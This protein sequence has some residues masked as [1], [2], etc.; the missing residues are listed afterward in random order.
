MLSKLDEF[1]V[2]LAL[3]ASYMPLE[4]GRDVFH[5]TS[6]GGFSSILFGNPEKAELWASR[7]DC[8]NDASEGAIV[9]DILREV[10]D[11]M[12]CE[13]KITQ[14]LHSLFSTV[15]P[16]RT[17]LL[18]HY[19]G[20]TLRITRPECDRY[21]CSFSKNND[22][23]AM[24]NYY[25]K[26]SK[27]EGFNIGFFPSC[28]ENSLKSY[29][30]NKEATFHIY[31]VVYDKAEQKRLVR[32]LLTQLVEH[33]SK[34][35]E[36]SIRYIISNRLLDWSLVFKSEYFR[37][38]EEVRIIIDVAKREKNIPVEYRMTAGYIVPY[39]KLQ[40]DKSDVSYANFGPLQCGEDQKQ[41][42][43]KVMEDMMEAKG[44]SVLVECSQ[45]P[46]RY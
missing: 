7:Y 42:Q 36:S 16:A 24:W 5:Y 15:R 3:D 43:L 13:E 14:D 41:H 38:E 29:L 17:M 23:L 33:Y 4:Y 12:L 32:R 40:L 37:H 11:D 28:I 39:I 30:Y 8:L 21:I 26:G 44:Y 45:V 34:D 20:D 10:C 27:Y 31:P 25:S 6:P 9:E 19:E 18:P 1:Q 35:Q 46:V 2:L 22:S